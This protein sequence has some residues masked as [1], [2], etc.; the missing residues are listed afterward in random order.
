M[1]SFP[2]KPAGKL[3][4]NEATTQPW[5]DITTDFIMVKSRLLTCGGKYQKHRY[6]LKNTS[7]QPQSL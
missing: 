5:K 6:V 2:E 3:K 1:K 4:P 7:H